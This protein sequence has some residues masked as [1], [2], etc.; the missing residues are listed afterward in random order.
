MIDCPQGTLGKDNLLL[1]Y[2]S[3]LPGENCK[4]F[5]DQLFRVFDRDG[6]GSID[7]KV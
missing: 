2:S 1:M 7:F 3:F 4:V 5:V 6:N